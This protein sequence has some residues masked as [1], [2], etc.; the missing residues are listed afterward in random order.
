MKSLL[1][2]LLA[3][4]QVFSLDYSDSYTG[5]RVQIP[6]EN[7]RIHIVSGE[8][9]N[10]GEI[11]QTNLISETMVVSVYGRKAHDDL[12]D[13]PEKNKAFGVIAKKE[14]FQNVSI[15]SFFS[16]RKI[17]DG[18]VMARVSTVFE[19]KT[20]DNKFLEFCITKMVLS[21]FK[22]NKD[23]LSVEWAKKIIDSRNKK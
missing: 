6:I 2:F 23:E 16:E 17:E 7:P 22:E 1:L 20:G 9:H 10:R 15:I 13:E 14:Y 11:S 18:L 4:V 8:I 12:L 3:Q 5:L 21:E 19:I